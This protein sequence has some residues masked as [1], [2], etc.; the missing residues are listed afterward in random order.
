MMI[1]VAYINAYSAIKLMIETKEYDFTIN[2]ICSA[3]PVCTACSRDEASWRPMTFLKERGEGGRGGEGRGE[4]K[5][6]GTDD[7]RHC[8]RS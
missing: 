5:R 1:V 2:C 6:G 7:R 8:T 3:F 4:Q